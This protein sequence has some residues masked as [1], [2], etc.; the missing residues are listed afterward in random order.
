[1]S[2]G[3]DPAFG[4]KAD[5]GGGSF[6]TSGGLTKR[7]YFAGLAMQAIITSSLKE[8]MDSAIVLGISTE[9]VVALIAAGHAD[10]LLDEMEKSA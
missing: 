7:E 8:A 9:H 4:W 5:C 10:A 2:K 3:N 6:I 1:M